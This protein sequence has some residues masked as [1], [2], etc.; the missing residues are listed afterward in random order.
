MCSKTAGSCSTAT[1]RRWAKTRMSRSSISGS[2]KAGAS[3]SVRASTT[4]GASAGWLNRC[5]ISRGLGDRRKPTIQLPHLKS[6]ARI[7]KQLL[8]VSTMSPPRF[9]KPQAECIASFFPSHL[10]LHPSARVRKQAFEKC[11]GVYQISGAEAFCELIINRLQQCHGFLAATLPLPEAHTIA[12]R[13]KLPGKGLLPP[14]SL[15]A[16]NEQTLDFAGC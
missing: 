3:R 5:P 4:G 9:S 10:R 16:L 2:R 15:Q 13:A 6:T 12:C 8:V 1:Q 7:G 14:S 11:L